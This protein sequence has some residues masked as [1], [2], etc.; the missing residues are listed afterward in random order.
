METVPLKFENGFVASICAS[1]HF[2]EEPR[3]SL[4]CFDEDGDWYRDVPGFEMPDDT[5][6]TFSAE[7]VVDFILAVQKLKEE[8]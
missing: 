6:Q 3:Y 4:A 5:Y 7:R 8:K 1:K 2:G